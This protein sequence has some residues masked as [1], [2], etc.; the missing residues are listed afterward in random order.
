MQERQARAETSRTVRTIPVAEPARSVGIA[1]SSCDAFVGEAALTRRLREQLCSAAALRCHVLI[2]G[3]LGAGRSRAARWLHAQGDARAPFL[4]LRGLPP[5]LGSLT[6]EATLFAPELDAAPLA[7]QAEWREWLARANA[8]VRLIASARGAFPMENADGELFAELRRF[9]LHVPALRERRDDFAALAVDLASE[10]ASVLGAAPFAFARG[11][12]EALARA[13]W[14]ASAADLRRALERIATSERAG[15]RVTAAIAS[16]AIED[17]RPNVAALRE[18]AVA[19]ERDALLAALA[20]TGGNLARAA[21][22]L[23]CSRAAV[24]RLIAK[25]GIALRAP[26]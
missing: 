9:A 21:R 7:V 14:I 13:P 17:M 10:V 16:A 11:A 6:G 3:E 12:L 22:R 24:Y 25:H 5:R 4:V 26:R 23:G 19:R 1:P 15:E 2:T 18:R 8:G 20:D